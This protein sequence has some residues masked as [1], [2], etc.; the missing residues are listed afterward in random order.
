MIFEH[1]QTLDIPA[2]L[3]GLT[4][5]SKEFGKILERATQKSKFGSI[6]N[7]IEKMQERFQEFRG[8]LM[9]HPYWA[10]ESWMK[11]L[12]KLQ[13]LKKDMDN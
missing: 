7:N 12:E 13:E 3:S 11:F 8:D 4:K 10:L 1:L 5:N 9:F 6:L 2:D